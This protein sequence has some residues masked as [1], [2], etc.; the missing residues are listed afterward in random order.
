MVRKRFTV[1]IRFHGI[2]SCFTVTSCILSFEILVQLIFEWNMFVNINL[3]FFVAWIERGFKC[4]DESNPDWITGKAWCR[5][6]RKLFTVTIINCYR[7]LHKEIIKLQGP[8]S[9]NCGGKFIFI[10]ACSLV[11]DLLQYNVSWFNTLFYVRRDINSQTLIPM[12]MVIPQYKIYLIFLVN[13]GP[14]CMMHVQ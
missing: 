13:V 12:E 11:T 4:T 1:W 2:A 8:R 10:F 14:E 9:L 5:Y 7:L 3:S 6:L